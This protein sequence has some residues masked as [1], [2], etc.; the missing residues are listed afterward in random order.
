MNL[1][2]NMNENLVIYFLYKL[3]NFSK[4]FLEVLLFAL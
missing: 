1:D 3:T 2:F 4:Q